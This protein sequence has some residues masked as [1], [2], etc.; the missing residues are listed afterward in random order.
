MLGD[1]VILE[2]QASGQRFKYAVPV[3]NKNFFVCQLSLKSV[4]SMVG[5]RQHENNILVILLSI[6][7]RP[8]TSAHSQSS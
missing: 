5:V 1:Y 8:C 3:I 2:F 4:I 6:N 7:L